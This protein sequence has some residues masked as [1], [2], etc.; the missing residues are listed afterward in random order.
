MI[1]KAEHTTNPIE[2][3]VETDHKACADAARRKTRY[4]ENWDWLEAHASEVY[5]H[6]GKFVCIAGQELFVG[7]AAIDVLRAAEAAHPD[8]DGRFTRY[9]PSVMGARIYAH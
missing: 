7:D 9:I 3:E 6:R 5:A 1:K 2:M 4:E 8:D